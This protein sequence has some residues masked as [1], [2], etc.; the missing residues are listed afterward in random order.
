M[1][2]SLWKDRCDRPILPVWLTQCQGLNNTSSQCCQWILGAGIV[3][4]TRG[5]ATLVPLCPQYASVLR[6]CHLHIH[7]LQL[8]PELAATV[9]TYIERRGYAESSRASGLTPSMASATSE[10]TACMTFRDVKSQR[11]QESSFGRKWVQL[12]CLLFSLFANKGVEVG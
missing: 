6:I 1:P 8:S 10:K 3:T 7:T 5:E 11:S 4:R 2:S 9:G 12:F